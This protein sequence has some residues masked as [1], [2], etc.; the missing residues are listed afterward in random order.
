MNDALA[1]P[2][3]DDATAAPS[4]QTEATNQAHLYIF[5][6]TDTDKVAQTLVWPG[7]LTREEIQKFAENLREALGSHGVFIDADAI[8]DTYYH[9]E[10]L[11][12]EID[13]DGF[14]AVAR[15]AANKAG[16]RLHVRTKYGLGALAFMAWAHKAGI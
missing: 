2:Q 4:P 10:K 11:R 3:S 16:I 8:A 1:T 6:D 5:V 12:G 9:A 13:Y 7:P 15:E 14:A